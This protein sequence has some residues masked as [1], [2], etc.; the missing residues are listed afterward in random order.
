MLRAV[1]RQLRNGSGIDHYYDYV[2][3]DLSAQE[4]ASIP[5]VAS[6]FRI[7]SQEA[8]QYE[9]GKTANHLID[10]DIRRALRGAEDWILIGGP[11]CQAYSLAGRAR[12]TNDTN[13]HKDEKHFLYREYLRIIRQHRPSI[14]VMENVKGLLSSHH[15]G[16]RMFTKILDDL[17]RPLPDLDY[18]IRSFVKHDEGLGLRPEEFLIETEKYGV[19]QTRH[20]VILLGVKRGFLTGRHEVLQHACPVSVADA[21]RDL[22]RIRSRLSDGSDTAKDWWRALRAAPRLVAGWGAAGEAQVIQTMRAAVREARTLDGAG[23]RFAP[24]S[25]PPSIGLREFSTWVRNDELGGVSQHEARSHMKTDLARYLFVASY[26]RVLGS[27]PTLSAFPHD[28][29]PAHKNAIPDRQSRAIPFADRFR[30]Q[31]ADA[32][33]STIVSHIAKDGNYYIHYDPAQCRSLTVREAAR[34]QTFPDDY[35][36]E[37]NRTQQ[38]TQVG[39]AVPPLLSWKLAEIVAQLVDMNRRRERVRF[40]STEPVAATKR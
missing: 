19:P 16:D 21:I 29:L 15:S 12:R 1:Y 26:A 18:D 31:C 25:P 3:G 6:S 4:F 33:S 20:R 5:R 38:Y 40:R 34:L 10:A 37:G 22:P 11:P 9:L 35:H 14:F 39:N 27:S 24:Y 2:R 7:A 28:L 23:G 13:F 17:S 8:R 36:F 30:V 32:P